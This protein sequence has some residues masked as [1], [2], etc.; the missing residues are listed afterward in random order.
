MA[1]SSIGFSIERSQAGFQLEHAPALAS[2]E[3]LALLEGLRTGVQ[4]AYESLIQRFEHPVYSIVSRLLN[5]PS[6]AP[7]VV[8]DV[9]VKIFRN[10]DHF[11][12]E[13]SLKTWV[14]RIAVNEARNQ[15]RWFG[16]HRRQEVDLEPATPEAHSL[17]D[18]LPDP[19]P[20]PFD[21][22]LDLETQ[23]LIEE[24]LAAVPGSYRTALVL[25]E[26]EGLPYDEIASILGISLGTVKSRILRGREALRCAI[27]EKMEPAVA[28]A[29]VPL[30]VSGTRAV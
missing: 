25:R 27:A 30:K 26:V 17:R 29:A 4:S 21:L 8:Q 15:R 1:D 20:S 28:R 10:V 11:R 16:R 22:A 19:G 18:I 7:D 24:A 9:F 14:Y 5:Q 23:T 2:Q 12:G 3:D 13:S 6:D